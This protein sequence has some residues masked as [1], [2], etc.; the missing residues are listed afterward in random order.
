MMAKK[1]ALGSDLRKVDAHVITEEEYDEIPELSEEWFAKATPMIGGR[2][3][4]ANE[5]RAAVKKAIGRAA[6]TSRVH[7]VGLGVS[8]SLTGGLTKHLSDRIGKNLTGSIRKELSIGKGPGVSKRVR[9]KRKARK[10][11]TP[12]RKRA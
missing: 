9:Q 1:R 2:V 10:T 12:K 3:A 11:A 6:G 5:F 7:G 4:G 8:K